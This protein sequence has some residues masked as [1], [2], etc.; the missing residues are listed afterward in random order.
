MRVRRNFALSRRALLRHKVRTALAISGTAVG[1]GAVL[2][3]VALGEGAEREVIEQIEAMG[4]NVLMVTAAPA[5]RLVGRAPRRGLVTTLKLSDA[6]AILEECP[7]VALTAPSQD[8]PFRVKYGTLS[9]NT[10]IRGT[11]P[12]FAEIRNFPPAAGRYFTREENRAGLRVALLG[13]Q[14]AD[15][16]FEGAD[17]LG[18]TVRI[19]RVPFEVIGVLQSK[20]M[21]IEGGSNEDNQIV[22][23]IRTAMRRVFNLDYLSMVYVQ[24]R[25][26]QDMELAE[27]QIARLLR[28]RH[29]LDRL[30]APDDFRIQSQRLVL[31]AEMETAASFRRMI[32]ALASV[33]LIVG[34]VGILS[35]MMLSIR[36]RRA[37]VGLRV[38]VGAK[39][40]D[41]RTQFLVEAILLGVVGGITGLAFGAVS[42]G[43]IGWWTEWRTLISVPATAL[44]FGAALAT[45]IIFGV[46]P[47][48][49][50][51]ALDPIE[52]LRA[53]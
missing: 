1:V 15:L 40:K 24:V 13:S 32:T 12:D 53:E 22:I 18:E 37:E 9:T 6:E 2:V 47:A 10:T 29:R 38:A 7:A 5:E 26:G 25:D 52:A 27:A 50:A 46:Y 34:G 49:R 16:L 11:S 23:P 19:G 39:R 51:A 28:S 31:A 44:A 33:A 35:I 17:P 20:G 45:A 42:A 8:R 36:E 48:Q 30:G 14:V 43:L 4:R 21:G 3:M 41:V